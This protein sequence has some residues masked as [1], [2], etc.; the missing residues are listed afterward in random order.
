MAFKSSLTIMLMSVL[1]NAHFHVTVTY[2]I[3]SELLSSL[4]QRHF[5]ISG[6]SCHSEISWSGMQSWVP[7]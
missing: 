4:S 3:L 2:V 1:S 6:P 7:W 5:M